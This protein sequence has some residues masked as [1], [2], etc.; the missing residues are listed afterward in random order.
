MSNNRFATVIGRLRWWIVGLMLTSII[1]ASYCAL[2]ALETNVNKVADWLP[3]TTPEMREFAWFCETFEGDEILVVTWDGCTVDDPRLDALAEAVVRPL[4]GLDGSEQAWFSWARTGRSVLR[5]L[6]DEPLSLSREEAL[7]RMANW[8]VGSDGR[9]SCAVLK[10]NEA[11]RDD[12]HSAVAAM[13]LAAR[14]FCNLSEDELRLGGAT[15]D[16]VAIDDESQR[17]IRVVLAISLA[18][19]VIG[20]FVL[21]RNARFVC[22]V[23]LTAGLCEVWSLAVVWLAGSNVDLVLVMMPVL[24][25]ILAVS[26]SIHL[27][28]YYTN[29]CLLRGTDG[30]AARA[31]R[32]SWKPATFSCVTTSL[33]LIS[34]L[35]SEVAPVRKFGVFSAVGIGLS[36]IILFLFLP[37][38]LECWPGSI[39]GGRPVVGNDRLQDRRRYPRSWARWFARESVRRYGMILAVTVVATPLLCFGTMR[40]RTSIKLQDMFNPRSTVIANYRRLEAEIGPLVPVEVVVR[41]HK[42]SPST[43]A[44]RLRLV[45]QIRLEIDAIDK[46]GGTISAATFAPPLPTGSGARQTAERRVILWKLERAKPRLMAMHYLA[47]T[48]DDELWRISAR[49]ETFNDLDYGDFLGQLRS[50]VDPLI[51]AADRKLG[52]DVGAI[53]T[54]GIPT[55]YVVQRRLLDD[56]RAGFGVAFLTIALVLSISLRSV[57][58]GLVTMIPNVL[59]VLIVFGFLGW[60]NI[61]VDLGSMLTISTALG[62]S[63]DN[64]LH[65]FN[66]FRTALR[67]GYGRRRALLSAYRRCGRSM[68]QTAVI[69]SLGMLVFAFSPFTPISRFG[70]LMSALIALAMLGDQLLLP[71]LLVSPLGSFFRGGTRGTGDAESLSPS[72]LRRT[73]EEPAAVP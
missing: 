40:I 48:G 69:C 63:V 22:L 35:V 52:E 8:T 23:L 56:L 17:S 33:G 15:F 2:R 42:A 67:R 59:P 34:L 4:P 53:V 26:A 46:V 5:D 14:R 24:V 43:L 54:G 11:G 16:S 73:T 6:T 62:I 27:L 58:A 41:F 12:R 29:E 72:R 7:R 71:A 70:C 50:V 36:L 60:S 13:K 55:F 21:L 64:E 1:P 25:G 10:V 51:A 44:D 66:W 31:V 61:V 19:G 38:A 68:A 20:S 45:E 47:T 32:R 49:V 28:N 65:F 18:V 9:T 3:T 37:A 39:R 57:S 30:A